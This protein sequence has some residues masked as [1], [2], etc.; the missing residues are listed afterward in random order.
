MHR[1]EQHFVLPLMCLRGKAQQYFVSLS[2]MFS[3][4]KTVLEIW[5]NIG[6]N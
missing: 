3:D 5:P 6:L 4:E 1:L 2:C